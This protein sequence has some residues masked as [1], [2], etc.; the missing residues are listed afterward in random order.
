MRTRTAPYAPTRRAYTQ[1]ERRRKISERVRMTRGVH[2]D[3]SKSGRTTRRGGRA[4]LRVVLIIL[5]AYTLGYTMQYCR[6]AATH[7]A[8]TVR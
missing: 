7:C 3:T 2:T 8:Y 4:R 5:A 6:D 1:T